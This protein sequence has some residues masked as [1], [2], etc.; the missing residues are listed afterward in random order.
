MKIRTMIGG[1]A[2]A[3]AALALGGWVS[4]ERAER[5]DEAA[6]RATLEHYLQGHATGDGSHMRIAFHPQASLWFVRD[7]KLATRSSEEYAAGFSG[8][9]PADEAK[10]KRWIESVDVSGS[11]AVGKIVL[12]Y[13]ATKFVDY[14]ALLKVDGE[15]KIIAK[16]FHAEPR[17]R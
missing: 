16:A 13:P 2:V 1:A 4:A 14:M 15:W 12:D 17:N 10:R 8:R 3:A 6:V 11:A 5:A 9:P 7:G